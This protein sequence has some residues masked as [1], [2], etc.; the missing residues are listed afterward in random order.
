M[1][2]CVRRVVEA[3]LH[4]V[5]RPAR[6]SAA[7]SAVTSATPTIPTVPAVLFVTMVLVQDHVVQN[8]TA[9]I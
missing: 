4:I 3:A 9:A 5:I 1:A 6:F 8:P 2:A 7:L